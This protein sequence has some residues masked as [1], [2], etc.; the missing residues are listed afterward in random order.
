MKYFFTLLLAWYVQDLMQILMTQTFL[1]PE[2]YAMVLMYCATIEYEPQM[3]FRWIAA[4]G[5][6]GLLFDLRWIG[7]PGL[8]ASLYLFSLL[9]ARWLWYRV[10]ASNRRM[11]PFMVITGGVL[12]FL[13]PFRLFFWDPSV[14]YGRVLLIVA[15]QWALSGVA[16]LIIAMF[17][18][19]GYDEL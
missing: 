3:P 14:L 2:I 5:I 1:A 11:L 9:A 13:T 16:L 18:S 7:I 10:P 8:C 19:Y 6:G 17:R 12:M 15:V 4:A